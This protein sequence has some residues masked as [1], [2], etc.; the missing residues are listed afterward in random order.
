MVAAAEFAQRP[1]AQAVEFEVDHRGGVERERLADD[2]SSGD[3]DAQRLAQLGAVAGDEGQ[4]QSRAQRGQRGHEDG[5]QPQRGGLIDGVARAGAMFA[6]RGEGEIDHENG[7]FFHNADQQEHTD[8]RNDGKLGVRELQ[9]QQR[10]QPGRGQ[11][12][13]NG[14]RVEGAFI[15]HAQHDVDGEDGGHDEQRLVFQRVRE[16]LRRA[17]EAAVNLGRQADG[18]GGVVDLGLDAAE[19]YALV[20]VE[21]K[22]GRDEQA[23][24][25][26]RQRGVGQFLM[27]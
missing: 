24:M 4:R 27:R 12:G 16:Q 3:G 26:D 21:R 7:V 14:E 6:F 2:Q 8:E 13:Q 22:G 9:G 20:E 10:A 5:A 15:Q 1:A 17:L 19:R 23:L 11:G 25:V 18:G